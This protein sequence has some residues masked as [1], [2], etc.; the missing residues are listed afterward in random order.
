VSIEAVDSVSVIVPEDEKPS[1]LKRLLYSSSLMR[2]VSPIAILLLWELLVRTHV[3]DARFVPAPSSVISSLVEMTASG[4]VFTHLASTIMRVVIG[5]SLGAFFGVALG[6]LL[7]L[8]S[9]L[10][11]LIQPLLAAIYPIPKIALFPLV[12]IMFGIGE[13]SKYV[14]VALAVFFQVFFST[15]A[16]VVNIDKTYLDVASNFRASLW[17]SYR[18]VAFPGALPY[19]FTGLQ[20]GL[21]MALITVVIAENFGTRYGVGF[22][23]WRSYQ[24]FEVADMFVGLILIAVLGYLAQLALLA[25]E[26]RVVPWKGSGG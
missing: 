10:R 2:V 1:V 19:I 22:I 7:G 5:F 21:G 23:V 17:Q 9:V 4:E 13:T 26:K 6:L 25:I 8:S 20:L 12:M 16:G 14:I 24:V 11:T 15:L 3:L 18:T